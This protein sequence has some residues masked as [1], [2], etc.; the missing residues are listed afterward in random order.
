MEDF[1]KYNGESEEDI[2]GLLDQI[3]Q[4]GTPYAEEPDPLYFANFRVR[5][6]ERVE[7]KSV[8]MGFFARAKEW[9]MES[10]LRTG[11]VGGTMAVVLLGTVY[12]GSQGGDSANVAQNDP[13]VVTQQQPPVNPGTIA[14]GDSATEQVTPSEQPKAIE[15]STEA[16]QIAENTPGTTPSTP[17]E[18]RDNAI[19]NDVAAAAPLL[20]ADNAGPAASLEDLTEAELESLL[21]SVEEMN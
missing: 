9:L 18:E 2:K 12:F 15:P 20:L 14:Q 5:V 6:M 7:E 8:R 19:V 17:V 16:P 11:L 3:R 13:A 1:K 4:Q 10:G 21:A